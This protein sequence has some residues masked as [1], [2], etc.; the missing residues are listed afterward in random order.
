MSRSDVS[1]SF[2]IPE[3]SRKSGRPPDSSDL[4]Q[5]LQRSQDYELRNRRRASNCARGASNKLSRRGFREGN[6][7]RYSSGHMSSVG[8]IEQSIVETSIDCM[9]VW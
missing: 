7:G 6:N 2:S 4:E 5:T 9:H 8:S 3:E 1:V